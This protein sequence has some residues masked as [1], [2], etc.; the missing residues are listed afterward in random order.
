M[1]ALGGGISSVRRAHICVG[2]RS[3]IHVY[4]TVSYTFGENVQLFVVGFELCTCLCDEAHA[5]S[6]VVSFAGWI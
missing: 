2:F 5:I 6:T 3:H 4:M 1:S